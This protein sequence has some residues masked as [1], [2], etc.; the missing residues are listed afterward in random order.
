MRSWSIILTFGL[1]LHRAY[2][3]ISKI[4]LLKNVKMI[5][6][7]MTDWPM[8]IIKIFFAAY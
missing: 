4:N 2:T 3:A 8:M 7:M 5:V 1:D 6:L